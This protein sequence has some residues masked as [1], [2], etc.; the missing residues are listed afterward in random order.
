VSADWWE[1]RQETMVFTRTKLYIYRK[2]WSLPLK[3]AGFRKIVPPLLRGRLESSVA[4]GAR[5]VY[6]G[7]SWCDHW[8]F[9]IIYILECIFI[10]LWYYDIIC[11]HNMKILYIYH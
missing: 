1:N 8:S 5:C 6:K 3:I 11:T 9:N 10:Y 2:S 7:L 4:L